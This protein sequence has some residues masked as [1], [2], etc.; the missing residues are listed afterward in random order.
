MVEVLTSILFFILKVVGCILS[1]F[2][3]SMFVFY[4]YFRIVKKMRLPKCEL[5]TV[6]KRSFFVRLLYDFP[7]R[8]ILDRFTLNP[9]VFKEK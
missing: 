8:F 9:N 2:I 6:R 4:L 7:K 1:P 5:N 3:I